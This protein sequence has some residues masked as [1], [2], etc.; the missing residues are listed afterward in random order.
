MS[1]IT[2][3]WK[4]SFH[5]SAI[6]AAASIG[7]VTSGFSSWSTTAILLVPLV[8]WARVYLRR[9]TLGQVIAG[10]MVGMSMGLFLLILGFVHK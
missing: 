2:V 3:W 10:G 7:L 8:G 4:I 5:S 1:T 6:S 9:H